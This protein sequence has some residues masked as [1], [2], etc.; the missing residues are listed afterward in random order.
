MISFPKA[1]RVSKG[2]KITST[3]AIGLAR[4]FNARTLSGIGDGH[5]RLFDYWVGL[6][7]AIRNCDESGEKCPSQAEY[8]YY[9]MM[10]RP[11]EGQWPDAAPGDPEGANLNNLGNAYEYGN[12]AAGYLDEASRL[13]VPLRLVGG[14]SDLVEYCHR[15]AR[16]QRGA[17]DPSTGVRAAPMID[18]ARAYDQVRTGPLSRIGTSWGGYQPQP[19]YV[20]QC[21]DPYDQV[22]SFARFFTN[23]KNPAIVKTYPGN[24]P[25]VPGDIAGIIERKREYVIYTYRGDGSCCVVEVLPT[26]EWIEGPYKAAAAPAHNWADHL[27]VMQNAFAREFRGYDP[28]QTPIGTRLSLARA[29]Y[30]QGFTT[31]QY[32]LAPARG[33]ERGQGVSAIYPVGR[34]SGPSGAGKSVIWTG[35]GPKWRVDSKCIICGIWAKGTG[36]LED[37]TLEIRIGGE[38]RGTLIV[39]SRAPSGKTGDAVPSVKVIFE[40]PKIGDLEV[41]CTNGLRAGSISVEADE[42]LQYIPGL[43]DLTAL[44]RLATTTGDG[45]RSVDTRGIDLAEPKEVSDNY[46]KYGCVLNISSADGLPQANT[47]I[48]G[49]VNS[50]PVWDAA[51]RLS[52]H[53]RLMPAFQIRA[54]AVSGGKSILYFDRYAKVMGKNNIDMFADLGP[55]T[56]AFASGELVT[57]VRYVVKSKDGRGSVSYAGA[58]YDANQ[59]FTAGKDKTFTA[60]GDAM[61]CEADGIRKVAPP[62]GRTNR[63]VMDLN[64]KPFSIHSSSIWHPSVYGDYWP[65]VSRCLF[66]PR[67]GRT[68]AMTRMIAGGDSS[69]SVPEAPS[70]W[71]YAPGTG[72]APDDV[73]H[74][75]SCPIYEPP[76]EVE[77]VVVE[78]VNGEDLIKVTLSGRLQAHE[79]APAVVDRDPTTWSSGDVAR[80][81][82]TDLDAPEDYRTKDNG[83][84][85]Y[86]LRKAT[87]YVPVWRIGDSS[88]GSWINTET[89]APSA[90]IWPSAL[91]VR[92]MDEPYEDGNDRQD[93][94]DTPFLSDW[95]TQADVVLRSMCEGFVDEATTSTYSCDCGDDSCQIFDYSFRNLCYDAFGGTSLQCLPAA[96]TG[97]N[98]W[99][100]GPLPCTYARA[101]IFNQFAAAIDKLTSARVML[102]ASLWA[103]TDVFKGGTPVG[104]TP[105]SS[106]GKISKTGNPAGGSTPDPGS[107]VDW[108]EITS[109]YVATASTSSGFAPY[110][111]D[112]NWMLGGSSNWLFGSER[113]VV[114]YQVRLT[115]VN[116]LQA[117]PLAW[118]DMVPNSLGAFVRK[119]KVRTIAVPINESMI[120][121]AH[122]RWPGTGWQTVEVERSISCSLDSNGVVDCGAVAPSPWYYASNYPAPGSGLTIVNECYGGGQIEIDLEVIA[123]N[124]FALKVPL[125]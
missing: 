83:L 81:A 78:T 30:N 117:I 24:C 75:K 15:L 55:L 17:Q 14:S 74:Y 7:R 92:L 50:N 122:N 71:N 95:F 82:L 67:F 26:S 5:W 106:S 125:V 57:G 60:H 84:R 77:S 100:Y 119:T 40:D 111:E 70:G 45:L 91:F 97:W 93:L 35:G 18:A 48:G 101:E 19:Q 47:L 29:F 107:Y 89:G 22:S 9:W 66:G 38:P 54:Y 28:A 112:N 53:V 88:F 99:G 13:D 64:L 76:I 105:C 46:W 94:T 113:K 1:P 85:E 20:G 59:V 108:A 65:W 2:A 23:L 25:D 32:Q 87:G 43:D 114:T 115:D 98:S 31:K 73:R 103:K 49:S 63:W 58:K 34:L 124:A 12:E 10:L 11:E 68:P 6:F 44:L 90:S 86:M 16:Y 96:E 21:A 118:R 52:Q 120:C 37:A 27:G 8:F 121:D 62:G 41:I 72:A 39:P 123:A 4:S 116:A 104:D 69:W 109:Y 42:L 80:L 51:R 79:S 33:K 56:G 61:V 110:C 102:P 3:Q 36:L